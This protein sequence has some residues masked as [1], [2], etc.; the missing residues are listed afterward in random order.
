MMHL[1]LD[2]VGHRKWIE[3]VRI[4]VQGMMPT[5]K[6][7]DEN[8]KKMQEKHSITQNAMA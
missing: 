5:T 7:E 4:R 8:I 2:P 1:Y 6:N 3:S